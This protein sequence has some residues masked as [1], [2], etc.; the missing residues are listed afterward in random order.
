MLALEGIRVVDLSQVLAGPYCTMLLGDLGADVVKIENPAAGDLSRDMAPILDDQTS[1]AYLMV[2][3]NKR[4]LAVDLKDPDGRALVHDLIAEADVLVENFRPGVADRLGVGFEDMF[5]RNDRLV[6]C[7]ISG[8][9]QTGPYSSRGGFDLIAQGM[10]GLMSITGEAGGNPVKCGIPITDLGAGLFAVYG[11]LGALFARE[12][13]GKGQRLD[14]SLLDVGVGL[15][16][17]EAAEHF[18]T[19]AVPQP[20]GSAHRLSAP[21]QAFRCADGYVTVGADGTRQWPVFC[22]VIGREDLITDE[23]FTNNELRLANLPTLVAEVERAMAAHPRAHWL[24]RLEE[25]GLPAGPINSVPEALVDP[26][27]T[28]REMVA[29]VTHERVGRQRVIGPVVKFSDTPAAIR[30]APPTLGQDSDSVAA[31][32]G[33]TADEITAMRARGVLV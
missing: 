28:H 6:Y 31:D 33:R 13:T 10:A 20:T 30:T 4:S 32:L 19:G 1:G 27:V 11:I 15:S 17:W 29:E 2:N 3:R 12:R 9:G 5:R 8:F 18:A 22:T 23:R 14:T 7:S 24:A 26:Q 25:N 21:Y 16:V